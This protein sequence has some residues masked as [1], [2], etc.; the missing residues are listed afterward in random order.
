M[1]PC[2]TDSEEVMVV[3][4]CLAAF[5]GGAVAFVVAAMNYG[6]LLALAILPV[7]AGVGVLVA[8]ALVA[9]RRRSQ[10]DTSC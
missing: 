3:Y 10:D 7:G 4:F 6:L 9:L 2:I 8:A 1:R 5:L